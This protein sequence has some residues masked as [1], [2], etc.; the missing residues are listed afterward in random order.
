MLSKT[1]RNLATPLLGGL[2]MMASI[3]P[4]A[5][6]S[7]REPLAAQKEPGPPKGAKD[8]AG[9]AAPVGDQEQALKAFLDEYRLAPGQ[10]LKRI[11]PPRPAGVGVWSRRRNLPRIGDVNQVRAMV[12]GWRDPNDLEIRTWMV[13]GK[14]GWSIR[15]LPILMKMDLDPLDIEGDPVL[16]ATEV[17][18]DWIVREG[19]PP[20]QLIRPLE[21]IIQRAIRRRISLELRR[22]ERDV[23]VARGRFRP[24]PLPGH[25]EGDVEIYAHQVVRDEDAGGGRGVF[26]S[27]LAAVARWIDRRIVNEVESPPKSMVSWR[28]NHRWPATEQNQREDHDEALVLKHVEE[29]TGL[30]FTREKRPMRVL[31]MGQ[32]KPAE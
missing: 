11:L 24:S 20:E 21:A 6:P 9:P 1:V 30:R 2:V 29:Q 10:N 17:S 4:L 19:V 13:G 26:S 8:G 16:L 31:Y 18:G 32:A 15:S 3:A 5:G 12:L 25:A 28:Y 23:V 7:L 14:K 27:F 22:V